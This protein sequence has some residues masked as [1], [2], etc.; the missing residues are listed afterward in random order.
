MYFRTVSE[1]VHSREPRAPRGS[2][3]PAVWCRHSI[4]PNKNGVDVPGDRRQEHRHG[5]PRRR[6]ARA[7]QERRTGGVSRAT[8]PE[9]EDA[10][11]DSDRILISHGADYT[12]PKVNTNKAAK[13]VKAALG[14]AAVAF[15][16]GASVGA[17]IDR[18]RSLV[19][20]ARQVPAALRASLRVRRPRRRA[21]GRR[22][23]GVGAPHPRLLDPL[24]RREQRPRHA[25]AL[26]DHGLWA[27][28]EGSILLWAL[29]LAGYLSFVASSSAAGRRPARRHR[30][31]SPASW[32]PCSSSRSCP[33]PPTRSELSKVPFDGRGPNPLLQNHMLMAFHPPILYLGYVG[34][35]VP[36]MF[37]H[38]RADHRALRRGL[39]RRHPAR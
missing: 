25:A 17:A 31:P 32:S 8:G 19:S 27:A 39:A 15:G 34:F 7:V 12:P 33:A 36:F 13:F 16:A 11:F 6:H 4:V 5:A 21:V 20:D 38:R 9:G 3:S 28:L 24:R 23:D 2:A 29:I 14:Y 30:A 1:A 35:T 22:R 26:H 37:A 10:P 18:V